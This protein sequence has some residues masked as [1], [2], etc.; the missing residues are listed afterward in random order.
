METAKVA[1]SLKGDKLYQRRARI[2]LPI[3]VRQAH[4]GARIYYADLAAELGMPNPRNLNYPLGSIGTALER[5]SKEWKEEIPQIQCLSVNQATELPGEGIGWFVRNIG[6]FKGLPLRKR[7]AIVDAVLARVFA[8]PRW[9]EVLAAFGL[10]P[11]ATG[12]KTVIESAAKYQGGGENDLH[13]A[14][15]RYV[16]ENPRVV[17]LPVRARVGEIEY[18]LPSGDSVD[19]YFSFASLRTAVEVKSRIS[20][21]ADIARGLFQCVKYKAVLDACI[22]AENSDDS[23]DATLVLEDRLPDDLRALRNTLGVTVIEQVR[24]ANP[25]PGQ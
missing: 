9:N 5:L 4:A 18:P 17:G 24:G 2:G 14:L 3:L 13:R 1:E 23:S 21:H 20:D 25:H 16:A 11:A 19:V 22:A 7:R 10:K 8:Y 12:Y 6:E 15:K